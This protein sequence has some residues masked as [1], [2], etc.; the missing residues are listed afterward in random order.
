VETLEDKLNKHNLAQPNY[1]I[2]SNGVRI[3]HPWWLTGGG[4]FHY[5]YFLEAIKKHGK[6]HYNRAFE[7]CAGHGFIGWELLT[8]SYCDELTFSDIYPP[9]IETCKKNAETLGYTSKVTAYLTGTISAIPE[10]E[11]WDLVVGNP[12]NS[13]DTEG[14]KSHNNDFAGQSPE[15]V[16]LACRLTVDQD[17][18]AHRDFFKEIKKHLNK[19]ADIFLSM[20]STVFVSMKSIY[21][22][23][24]FEL[25]SVTDMIPWDPDLKVA[26]F[27]YIE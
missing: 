22:P 17:W 6:S 19:D 3:D 20:H 2:L 15:M 12:P 18:Q 5:P 14:F 24:N 11:K 27:K 8:N 10:E 7:W 9:S 26:H 4:N 1:S 23:E 21:Q 13:E 25:V 16:D